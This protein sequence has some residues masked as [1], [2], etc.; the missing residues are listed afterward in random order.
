MNVLSEQ[1]AVCYLANTYAMDSYKIHI[2]RPGET[3]DAVIKLLGRH[4]LSLAEMIPLRQKFNVLNNGV[5][6]RPGMTF[7]IPLP[8]M[9]QDADHQ[10]CVENANNSERCDDETSRIVNDE[11]Q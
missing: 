8:S 2:F 3:I 4:N 5:L 6:P 1:E 9:P 7:K 11:P 10:S